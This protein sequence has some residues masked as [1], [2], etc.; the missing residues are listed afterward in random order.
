A[1]NP[2]I[3]WLLCNVK[4]R[5][6]GSKPLGMHRLDSTRR[7]GPK[8]QFEALVAEC[9][10][11]RPISLSASEL[12][13]VSLLFTTSRPWVG[14]TQ[15]R[16]SAAIHRPSPAAPPPCRCAWTSPRLP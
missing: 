8:E 16:V 6:L 5:Q 3:P 13:R 4:S 9:L 1:G 14:S 11:Q 7:T 10:D 2:E 12:Y 15:T